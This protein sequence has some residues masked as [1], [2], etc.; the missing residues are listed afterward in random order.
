MKVYAII[1][2]E[3]EDEKKHLYHVHKVFKTKDLAL[4][5]LIRYNF[6]NDQLIEF[7]VIESFDDE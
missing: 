1:L 2:D 3:E 7:D 6:N 4:E 5:Y